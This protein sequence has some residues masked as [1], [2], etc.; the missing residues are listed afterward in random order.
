MKRRDDRATGLQAK[1]KGNEVLGLFGHKDNT[2]DSKV[3]LSEDGK[4]EKMKT[5][6]DGKKDK[7]RKVEVK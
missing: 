6:L 1:E 7:E 2:A 5:M 4:H 3:Q